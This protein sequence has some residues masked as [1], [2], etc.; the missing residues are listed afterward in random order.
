MNIYEVWFSL[1]NS[2]SYVVS[3]INSMEDEDGLGELST[4]L[5]AFIDD[6]FLNTTINQDD[7]AIDNFDDM[8]YKDDISYL[9]GNAPVLKP[10]PLYLNP[11]HVMP[12][13]LS[14]QNTGN[15]F[16][17][18][19]PIESTISYFMKHDETEMVEGFESLPSE[20]Q[21]KIFDLLLQKSHVASD[22][23]NGLNSIKSL[24]I[25]LLNA[26]KFLEMFIK[27]IPEIKVRSEDK[28]NEFL[29]Q[30]NNFILYKEYYDTVF[31]SMHSNAIHTYNQ[32]VEQFRKSSCYFNSNRLKIIFINALMVIF[33]DLR[34]FQE[35]EKEVSIYLT[36]YKDSCSTFSN[37]L[38]I[39]SDKTHQE[40]C[41]IKFQLNKINKLLNNKLLNK[42]TKDQLALTLGFVTQKINNLNHVCKF[43]IM[44]EYGMM[45]T[46]LKKEL[47]TPP[48]F[49]FWCW[50]KIEI[51][52]N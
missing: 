21:R 28:Y 13:E 5:I 46:S 52:N 50:I 32:L 48:I 42:D 26:Y 4:I 14:L 27:S 9:L 38:N 16:A 36:N 43:Q 47:I 11:L 40:I 49:H 23:Y 24:I 18:T 31:S 22:F 37:W 3:T 19:V 6:S 51:F 12:N 25:E 41:Y 35:K 29:K 17:Y 39:Y 30:A 1:F 45:L 2:Y 15:S 34:L 8:S 7:R 20:A 10:N 33:E 44:Y